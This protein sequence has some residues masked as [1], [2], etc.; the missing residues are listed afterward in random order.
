[1]S[2]EAYTVLALGMRYWF[3]LLGAVIVLRSFFL[4]SREH[5]ERHR[6]LR[7][8]PDAGMI[9]EMVV[10]EDGEHVR[11]GDTFAVPWEGNLGKSRFCDVSLQEAGITGVH[12]WFSFDR[13]DGL[14]LE[15]SN[16]C[17]CAVNGKE[18]SIRSPRHERTLG[19]GGY[20]EVGGAL[21]RLRLFAGLDAKKNAWTEDRAY[22]PQAPVSPHLPDWELPLEEDGTV[23][24]PKR[25]GLFGL[26]GRRRGHGE[27]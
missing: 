8:L 15:P 27:R 11:R 7:H 16:R 6:K 5:R 2:S 25:K 14:V 4:L 13:R 9:G 26:F 12:L 19:H 1:M 24:E 22:L 3:V 18:I 20:L 21:L 23:T 17:V 10:M